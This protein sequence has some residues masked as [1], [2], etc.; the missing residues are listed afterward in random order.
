MAAAEHLT[1]VTLE[2]GGKSPAI[3]TPPANLDVAAKRIVWG[4]F[5]NAGQTCIAPDYVL[6]ERSVHD[7]LVDAWWRS[8]VSSTAT[9]PGQSPDYAR[10]VNAAHFHRLEK[11]LDS[12]TAAVGGDGRPRPSLHRPHHPHRR[13]ARRSPV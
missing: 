11:L 4:K 3:V 10:I 5:L 7:E 13:R 1:P 8:W 2:L 12:G 6:V 9:D